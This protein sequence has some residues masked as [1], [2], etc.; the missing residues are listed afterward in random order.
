[1]F[2]V[3][4]QEYYQNNQFQNRSTFGFM[5][6]PCCIERIACLLV[7]NHEQ[8]HLSCEMIGTSRKLN[9]QERHYLP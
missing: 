6:K 8:H 4:F 9:Q 2:L 3:K 5:E 7:L 1:M